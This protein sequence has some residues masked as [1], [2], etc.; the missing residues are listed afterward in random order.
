M[1][2]E[3][4]A[5]VRQAFLNSRKRG[6]TIVYPPLTRRVRLRLWLHG[7]VDDVAYWLIC[8]DHITAGRRLWQ[9]FRMW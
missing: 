8:H 5:A 7:H 1:T 2:E 9:L 4:I 3:E 6:T